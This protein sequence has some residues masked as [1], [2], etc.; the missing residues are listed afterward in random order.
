MLR[1]GSGAVYMGK[2]DEGN[3]TDGVNASYKLVK[4][5]RSLVKQGLRKWNNK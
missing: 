1:F 4:S 5:R 3:K 2:W